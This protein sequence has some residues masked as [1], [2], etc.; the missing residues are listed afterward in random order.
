[1]INCTHQGADCVAAL[2][3]YPVLD[4]G[5]EIVFFLGMHRDV[6]HEHELETQLRQQKTR[7]ETVVDAAPVLGVLLDESGKVFRDNHE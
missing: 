5:G 2:T 4:Q 6:T 3:I 1:V 7:I